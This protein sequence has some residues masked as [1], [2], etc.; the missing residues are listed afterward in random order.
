MIA[1][2]TGPQATHAVLEYC[3]GGSLQRHLQLLQNREFCGAVVCFLKSDSVRSS[4]SS[5]WAPAP[6]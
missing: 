1:E 3:E 5:P 6:S 2:H 4:L